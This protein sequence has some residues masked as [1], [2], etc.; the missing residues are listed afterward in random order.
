M[1]E[2]EPPAVVD[3]PEQ[4]CSLKVSWSLPALCFCH[5]VDIQ[6]TEKQVLY[7]NVQ[8]CPILSP[9]KKEKKPSQ[10][11]GAAFLGTGWAM[12]CRSG[13]AGA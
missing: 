12:L 3:Q 11:L 5:S 6:A 4:P 2:A 7:T 13:S 10:Q 8:F 9:T 1:G